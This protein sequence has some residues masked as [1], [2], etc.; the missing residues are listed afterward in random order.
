MPDCSTIHPSRVKHRNYIFRFEFRANPPLPP[1]HRIF[2]LL[3][4]KDSRRF[5]KLSSFVHSRDFNKYVLLKH[6]NLRPSVYKTKSME[7]SAT[8]SA[9]VSSNSFLSTPI[10]YLLESFSTLK[11]VLTRKVDFWYFSRVY[12]KSTSWVTISMLNTIHFTRKS[13][14]TRD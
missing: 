8:P 2:S 1:Q 7:S 9:G 10:S 13:E 6:I 3:N 12:A 4:F 5:W 11:F 14:K